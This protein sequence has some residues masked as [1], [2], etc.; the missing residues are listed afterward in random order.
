MQVKIQ[1]RVYMGSVLKR[2]ENVIVSRCWFALVCL[3]LKC[4]LGQITYVFVLY[5]FAS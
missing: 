4:V 3:A 1:M 2:P 5:T